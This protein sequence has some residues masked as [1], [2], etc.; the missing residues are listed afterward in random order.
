MQRNRLQLLT[1]PA[2]VL[3]MALAGPAADISAQPLPPERIPE[4]T[5]VSNLALLSQS[6]PR[7]LPESHRPFRKGETLRLV[8][9]LPQPAQEVQPYGWR[10]SDH[11]QR[12]RMHVGHDLIAPA[13]T[14]V[15]AMLSGRVQ[16]VR[17]IS[18]YGLTV[19]LEH[20]RGWQTVYAHL[21][22]SNV[23]VGQLV[24]AGDGIGRVGRSGSASTD[25][26]HVELRRLEGRQAFALNLGLLL[27]Q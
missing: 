11:R 21:Q 2:V 22:S 17:S 19:L 13:A 4:R 26:L 15:R 16:L 25:H 10:Y 8:Y 18:G 9:P 12:W 27:P 24:H 7:R 23:R 6:R 5:G 20:G 1:L 14:P 3:V